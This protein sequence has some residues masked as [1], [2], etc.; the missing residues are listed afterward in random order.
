MSALKLSFI[1]EAIDRATAPV[2]KVNERLDKITEPVRRIRASVNALARE[3]G[4]PGVARQAAV[5]GERF[6]GVTSAL[7][8]IGAAGL[9][10]A[11]G[12]AA[13]W[14]PMKRVIDDASKIGDTANMLGMSA[15]EFQRISYALTLDGSSAEDAANSLRFLQK[16][17]QDA[18]RGSK[19]LQKAFERV[20]MSAAFVTKNLGDP[21]A[22]L[23]R[24][25]DGMAKLPT[26][27]ARIE[28][29]MTLMGKGG[30]K[31]IQTLSQGADVIRRLGDEAEA[32][33]TVLSDDMVKR[34]KDTGDELTKVRAVLT[35]VARV[36]TAVALPVID[37]IAGQTKA[38]AI[39]NRALIASRV[40]EFVERLTARLPQI[41]D[42]TLR[43]VSAIGAAIV[44][45]DRIV[46]AMGGWTTVITALAVVLGVKLLV[47]VVLL[48]AAIGKLT[49]A[50]VK[51]LLLM[52]ASPIGPFLAAIG[53]LAGAAFLVY[54]NWAPI[55]EFFTTLWE[56]ITGAATDGI[57]FIMGK[58]NAVLAFVQ[59]AILKLDGM[60]PEW[61]KKWTLP[62]AALAAAA[63][64]V[65]PAGAIATAANAARPAVAP[66]ALPGN[67]AAKA[68]VGGT[69]NIK[70][71]QDGRARVASM[72]SDNP[73]IGY[74]VD[75][76]V[77]LPTY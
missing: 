26:Q 59:G 63:N 50:F 28:S 54:K 44:A 22:L 10:A 61:V 71:D 34:F 18:I 39:A 40:G 77:M 7:R 27:A 37:R 6:R 68:D 52:L 76:G 53:L 23:M 20:G 69:I 30:A 48:G 29:G 67:L 3:S 72:R 15:R 42:T 58:V 32:T 70:I 16:N 8:G 1:I 4:L 46:Q 75:T 65:R 35:G 55:A 64:A 11:A 17:A 45:T 51:F 5:V 2:K 25:S 21:A 74:D 24:L 43:I 49:L 31:T 13:L 14:F 56:G 60:M 41:V 38:W 19:E 57:E 47:S 33:G 73:G 66:S 36:I 62:G 9:V 12:V